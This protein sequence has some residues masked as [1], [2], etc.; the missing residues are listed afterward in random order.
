MIWLDNVRLAASFAVI[1]LHVAAIV[2]LKSDFGSSSWWAGNIYDSFVR[3][4]IPV[5]VML[6]GALLLDPSK[7]GDFALFYKK[8]ISRILIPLAFWS[9][10]FLCWNYSKTFVTG[11]K[12]TVLSLLGT[13]ASGKPH[14]HMWF[15]FMIAGLYAF[16]P[17]FQ[18]IAAYANRRDLFLLVVLSFVFAMLAPLRKTFLGLEAG[19]LPFIY[20]FLPYVSYFF[21]GHLFKTYDISV[22]KITAGGT[23]IFF[24]VVTS[25]GAFC[26][27]APPF[28]FEGGTYFYGYFSVTVVPM[29]LGVMCLLK[30]WTT[31]LFSEPMTK[32]LSALAFGVYLIHPVVLETMSFFGVEPLAFCPALSIPLLS[33][34]V[35]SISLLIAALLYRTPYLRRTI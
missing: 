33:V 35:Y 12:T 15:L 2:V 8:R 17:F 27:S 9:V 10:F 21:C 11:N 7:S 28:T 5:F 23:A 22:S 32:K 31:P 16:T 34:A 3:W 26:L 24:A 1:V 25:L 19:S 13:L 18:M 20:W 14:Y 30:L 29:S 6:S 4:C